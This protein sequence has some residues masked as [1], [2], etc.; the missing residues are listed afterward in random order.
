M[1]KVGDKVAYPMHG[2]AII[3]DVEKE[4]EHGEE[5]QYFVLEPCLGHLKIKVP[6]AM[7]EKLGIRYIVSE[8]EANSV[9]NDFISCDC[10]E[11]AN[12]NKRYRD[13]LEALK[14]GNLSEIAKITKSLMLRD[15]KKSLS[16]A[17]RKMLT[18]AKTVLISE[19]IMSKNSTYDD[20]ETILTD[21]IS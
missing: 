11:E 12:W 8:N 6:V 13:N 4:T 21:K 5:N 17:E 14:G 19:L 16:N 15:R 1:F 3:K 18:N 20:I 10:V 9:I 2:A 7:I